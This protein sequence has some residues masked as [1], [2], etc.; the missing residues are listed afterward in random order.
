MPK[1]RASWMGIA[2]ALFLALVEAQAGG[3]YQNPPENLDKV[4]ASASKAQELLKQGQTD[5]A[6]AS[7]QEA[8][9]LAK[10]SNEMKSTAPM[11]RATGQLRMIVGKIKRGETAQAAEQLQQILGYLDG[12]LKSYQ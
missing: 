1:Y 5:A 9:Q 7:A 8:L 4:I 12:V 6:L 10:E 3:R 11:Q 2:L